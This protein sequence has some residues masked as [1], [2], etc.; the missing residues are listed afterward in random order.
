[1]PVASYYNPYE[2]FATGSGRWVKSQ[3]HCHNIRAKPTRG[4]VAEGFEDVLA[5]YK[6]SDYGLVMHSGQKGWYDTRAAAR[7]TGIATVNGQEY[8][9]YD[10]ILLVG[11]DHFIEGEPQEAIDQC[12]QGGGFAVICHPN[13]NPALNAVLAAVPRLLPKAVAATLNG[14][15]GVEVY[16]GC[17]PRR[18][19]AGVS[20]GAG[21]ATDFW[22]D[23]LS[24]GKRLWGFGTDDSHDRYEIN[25]GWTD[26]FADDTSFEAI[27]AAVAR[28]SICASRGLRLYGF[29]FDG[30]TLEVTAD[31][32]Y[33]RTNNIRYRAIGQGGKPLAEATGASLIYRVTGEEKYVRVEATAAD[34][35]MLWTQPLLR[36]SDFPDATSQDRR[37]RSPADI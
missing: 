31:M 3:F 29:V 4:E 8:V 14:A 21:L 12:V 6:A 36:A 5:E 23:A 28:G 26:I 2:I 1:M 32:A 19:H 37:P 9:S 18:A 7:A 20:F 24:S 34:G 35:S 25:V 22:D 17:L 13:Q 10:G 15:I 33:Y 30:T 16:N 27:K 11:T